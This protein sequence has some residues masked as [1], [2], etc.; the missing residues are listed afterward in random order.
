MK[1]EVRVLAVTLLSAICI[2]GYGFD[3]SAAAALNNIVPSATPSP[4]KKTTPRPIQSPVTSP[5]RTRSNGSQIA[6][7]SADLNRTETV[8][9]NERI[10]IKKSST[11]T[12]G[13]QPGAQNGNGTGA[14]SRTGRTPKSFH[15]EADGCSGGCPSSVTNRTSPSKRNVRSSSQTSSPARS[16]QPKAVKKN[17][18]I[19]VEND[20]THVARPSNAGSNTAPP[21]QGAPQCSSNKNC[22]EFEAVRNGRTQNRVSIP[23]TNV[24][25]A[26]SSTKRSKPRKP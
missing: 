13:N 11:P 17:Q 24:K 26:K 3:P 1:R 20:E 15:I 16:S 14:A 23:A 5:T 25:S 19:E 6:N 18:D 9:H 22:Q 8:D 12:S 10:T 4:R 2:S 7:P 21:A